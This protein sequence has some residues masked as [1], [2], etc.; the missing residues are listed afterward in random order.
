[1]HTLRRRMLLAPMVVVMA[2]SAGVVSVAPVSAAAAQPYGYGVHSGDYG[3][4]WILDMYDQ[5][6]EYPAVSCRYDHAR[7]LRSLSIRPPVV[8][9]HDRSSHLDRQYLAW[10]A[11]IQSSTTPSSEPWDEVGRT[12][13]EVKSATDETS[14]AFGPASFVIPTEPGLP[15]DAVVR[16]IYRMWWYWPNKGDISGRASDGVYWLRVRTPFES[17]LTDGWCDT[18]MGPAAVLDPYGYGTHE[19]RYGAHW[20]LD[21]VGPNPEYPAVTCVYDLESP[22]DPGYRL[23]RFR[24]RGPV[25]LAYD[26]TDGADT[27]YVGWRARIQLLDGSSWVTIDHTPTSRARASDTHWPSFDNRTYTVGAGRRDDQLRVVF[28]LFWYGADGVTVQARATH[29]PKWY[30]WN[31]GGR[32][33]DYCRGQLLTG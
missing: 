28:D 16:V 5:S 8:Y 6:T 33:T 10:R 1:M 3:R 29:F 14:A 13:L 21:G 27:R 19:G 7:K 17:G 2:L 15:S 25:M 23:L 18:L 30:A 11:Y 24:I 12:P 9:A 4:H 32:T 31:N 20:I 26:R 22:P